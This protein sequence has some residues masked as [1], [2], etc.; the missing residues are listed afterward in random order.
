LE[1]N[2]W[3]LGKEALMN[4]IPKAAEPL[5]QE[6]AG[7]FTRPTYPRFVVL[8]L[9][10]I[11]TT[12]RRTISNLLRTVQSLVPGH[13][14]SDHRVLS[15]RR[16][17]SWKL[18]CVLAG[19]ILRHWIPEGAVHLCGDDTV[20]EHRGKKVYGK[21]CARDAVRSTHSFTAYR[22]GHK[23]VVLAILVK[24]PFARRRWDN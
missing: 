2:P 24:F 22:W 8:L 5:I 21:A 3:Y 9:A 14:S 13:P 18:A 7:A 6:F 17:S 15:R 16:W 4:R 20:D 10:T 23:G 19:S 1:N 11:L 12:G